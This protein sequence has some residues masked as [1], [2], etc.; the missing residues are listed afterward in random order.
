M[1]G[2]IGLGIFTE[3]APRP[4]QSISGIVPL[5][6]CLFVCGVSPRCKFLLE[7]GRQVTGD[8]FPPPSIFSC[9]EQL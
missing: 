7:S 4:I 8:H 6:V 1:P 2:Y 3:S 5:S 9:P